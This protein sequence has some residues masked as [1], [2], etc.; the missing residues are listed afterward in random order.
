MINVEQSDR[1][2]AL[3]PYLFVRLD[4]M[5]AEARAKGIDVIDLG[6]GDPD[7]PTPGHIIEAIKRAVEEPANHQ[8]PSTAGLQSFQEAC[9]G[10]MAKRFKVDIEPK[11]VVS[12][13][14]SKEGLA[15][16]PLAFLNP[17]DVA[18]VPSPAYPVYKIGTLFAGG[19]SYMV[20]LKAENKFLPD[21]DAIPKD[22][23]KKAKILFIN[24][25]NN[26]TAAVAELDFFQKAVAFAKKNEIIILHD[27]AYEELA[28]DG[29]EP[30]SILE[31]P[32]AMDCAIEL[33][34]L[35]KTFN[36]TGWRIGF[37]A[38]CPEAVAAL[39]RVKSNIDSGVF[40]A[41]QLAAVEA[42]DKYEQDVKVVRELY[43]RRRDVLA[44]GLESLGIEFQKPK[45]TFYIWA[46][47]PSGYTSEEF[48]AM[49]LDKAGIMSSPGNGYGPEGEGYF[50]MAMIVD[51]ARMKEAVERMGR[52]KL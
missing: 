23:A 38:G 13:I 7:Q 24:Y 51:E 4:A 43:Q 46:K 37:A 29:F 8:Y 2:K 28:F 18:L 44:E 11:T 48:V 16:F 22:V 41:V 17:G 35:S 5:K 1:L 45:A 30:P 49:L 20:P 25:P 19:E 21:L 27:C 52:I 9:A 15:H 33:H 3:P 10:Y 14:G 47:V 39:G 32:G 34:S 31:V 6:I 50:R 40:Q 26:P 36:M 42:L 12:L